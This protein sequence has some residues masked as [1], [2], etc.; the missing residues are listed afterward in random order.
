MSSY[1]NKPSLSFIYHYLNQHHDHLLLHNNY[2]DCR[3]FTRRFLGLSTSFS[4][5]LIEKKRVKGKVWLLTS[6]RSPFFIPQTLPSSSSWRNRCEDR[7]TSHPSREQKNASWEMD[8]SHVKNN[9]FIFFEEKFDAWAL[10]ST[11][12]DS[13]RVYPSL[14]LHL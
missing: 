10:I 7:E 2:H 12:K 5:T 3:F 11:G 1:R 9:T 8:S 4:P 14:I 6:S 13:L